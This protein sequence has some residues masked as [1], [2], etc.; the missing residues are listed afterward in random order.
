MDEDEPR[1]GTRAPN[2]VR[3]RR[4]FPAEGPDAGH[5]DVGEQPPAALD[6]LLEHAPQR[7]VTRDHDHREGS[8]P[9]H[10]GTIGSAP[11]KPHWGFALEA[12]VL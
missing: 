7:R 4:A 1:I 12:E 10:A 6:E 11:G 9:D 2:G 3:E 5:H 8:V